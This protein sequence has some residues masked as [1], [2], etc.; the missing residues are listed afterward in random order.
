LR[1]DIRYRACHDTAIF[2]FAHCNSIGTALKAEQV[3]IQAR[4]GPD[5]KQENLHREQ[6]REK[7]RKP[8]TIILCTEVH[9]LEIS[10]LY[11]ISPSTWPQPYL[12]AP[13]W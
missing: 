7:D 13:T 4:D 8:Q 1:E 3:V 6:T 12:L 11:T 10:N 9:L 2:T 5:H